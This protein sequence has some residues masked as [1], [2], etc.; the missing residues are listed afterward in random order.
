MIEQNKRQPAAAPEA[1]VWQRRYIGAT[2]G[3]RPVEWHTITKDEFEATK[4]GKWADRYEVRAL[5]AAPVTA[6]P[7]IDLKAFRGPVAFWF[8]HLVTHP[9][10]ETNAARLREAKRLLALLDA[11]PKGEDSIASAFDRAVL[12]PMRREAKADSPKGGSEACAWAGDGEGNWHTGCG[13]IFMLIDGSPTDN[14][15]RH[16]PYCGSHISESAQAGDAEV[17]P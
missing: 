5:Y 2:R 15:M 9:Y 13:S 1:V 12:E 14:K 8:E 10:T 16:C 6:A 3:N 17:Q 4:A 7:G 11:S